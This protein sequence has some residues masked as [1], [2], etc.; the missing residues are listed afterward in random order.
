MSSRGE[1]TELLVGLDVE[2]LTLN[3]TWINLARE[4]HS[5]VRLYILEG[6]DHRGFDNCLEPAGQCAY[7]VPR[8]S[9]VRASW[10]L[11][12]FQTINIVQMPYD[13]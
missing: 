6:F 5:L 2:G 12:K 1:E 8:S 4:P 3:I 9:N 11:L 7:V 13:Q 10:H